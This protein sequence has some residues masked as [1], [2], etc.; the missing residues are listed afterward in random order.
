MADSD[1]AA[2]RQAGSVDGGPA[3]CASQVHGAL[4]G[5]GHVCVV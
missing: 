4:S 5:V 2:S 1:R 3:V